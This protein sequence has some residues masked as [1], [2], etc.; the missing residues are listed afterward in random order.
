MSKPCVL[1]V[2]DDMDLRYLYAYVLYT[3]FEVRTAQNGA[4]AIME[5]LS[6][7]PDVIITD[8]NLPLLDG[9]EFIQTVKRDTD[10]ATVPILVVSG[11]SRESLA[12]AS[13]AGAAKVIAKPVDPNSLLAEL[14][15]MLP[16]TRSH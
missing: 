13:N 14:L 4:D 16:E 5:V 9:I 8:I 6:H 1:I 12:Q 7:R 3:G 10:C 11:A 2:E 15:E